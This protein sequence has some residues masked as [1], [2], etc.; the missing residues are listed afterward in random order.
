MQQDYHQ[1][2]HFLLARLSV[3]FEAPAA[4]VR[5]Y[6]RP[7]A[8]LPLALLPRLSSLGCKPGLQLVWARISLS[9]NRPR[10]HPTQYSMCYFLR[11]TIP[12][13]LSTNLTLATGNYWA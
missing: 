9:A 2:Y 1:D 6:P 7:L 11:I 10:S 13:A 4:S 12:F 3:A 8:T 5:S